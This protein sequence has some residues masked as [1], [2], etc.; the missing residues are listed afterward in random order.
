MSRPL[1]SSNRLL[2]SGVVRLVCVTETLSRAIHAGS[3]RTLKVMVSLPVPVTANEYS[4]QLTPVL[5]LV[6]LSNVVLSH[7][8]LKSLGLS[9][10][11]A[12]QKLKVYWVPGVSL[13]VWLIVPS[14]P[15]LRPNGVKSA[16]LGARIGG[17]WAGDH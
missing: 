12:N 7:K 9:P 14:L 3:S 13:I 2:G 17:E 4:V 16:V 15:I 1:P 8:A 10:T 6:R 11:E 5:G